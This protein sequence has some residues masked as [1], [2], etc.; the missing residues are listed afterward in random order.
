M[1]A[2]HGSIGI[3]VVGKFSAGVSRRAKCLNSVNEMLL[4]HTGRGQRE[5]H[6]PQ[7][8]HYET[9]QDDFSVI[10]IP[11][12]ISEIQNHSSGQDNREKCDYISHVEEDDKGFGALE[13]PVLPRRFP[14]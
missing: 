1:E 4:N 11:V 2:G 13:S 8:G 7:K 5:K 6:K 3:V 12:T 14:K 10:L 9:Y